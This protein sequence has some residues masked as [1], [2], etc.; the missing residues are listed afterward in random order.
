MRKEY[1]ESE[2][3]E[4]IFIFGYKDGKQTGTGY[5]EDVFVINYRN[6]DDFN[7]I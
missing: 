1:Y 4:N 5:Y 2:E 3:E 7:H 6:S